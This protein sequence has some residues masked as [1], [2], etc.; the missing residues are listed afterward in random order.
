MRIYFARAPRGCDVARKATWQRHADPRSAYVAHY[1]YYIHILHIDSIRG[2]QPP[3][4]REG[5]RPFKSSGLINPTIFLFYFRV[6]LIHT[7]ITQ[8]TWRDEERRIS[9]ASEDPR[10]DRVDADHLI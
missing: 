7:S 5:I 2:I 6:G 4:Y 9:G 1:T 3:V 8:V 10:V